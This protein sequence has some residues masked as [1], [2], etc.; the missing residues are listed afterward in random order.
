MK[1]N[2]HAAAAVKGLEDAI[3]ARLGAVPGVDAV[4]KDQLSTALQ[5]QARKV[6]GGSAFGGGVRGERKRGNRG[7]EGGRSL[8]SGSRNT[9]S[10]HLTP[11]VQVRLSMFLTRKGVVAEET[12][13]RDME[14]V[15]REAA[16]F[17]QARVTQLAPT[18]PQSFKFFVHVFNT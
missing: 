9:A 17:S 7:E 3:R 15:A 11:I 10:T 5:N 2:R 12:I 4:A 14:E 6:G 13:R 8:F 1:A 16:L 18:L